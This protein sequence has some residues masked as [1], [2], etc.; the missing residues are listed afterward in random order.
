MMYQMDY[1]LVIDLVGL[2]QADKGTSNNP[3][4]IFKK[5]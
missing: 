2:D 1:Q 3:A 5:H 4:T